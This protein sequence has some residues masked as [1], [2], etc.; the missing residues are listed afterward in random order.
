MLHIGHGTQYKEKATGTENFSPCHL[1]DT[2]LQMSDIVYFETL[3]AED[4]AEDLVDNSTSAESSTDEEDDDRQA[5]KRATPTRH[6]PDTNYHLWTLCNAPIMNLLISGNQPPTLS[7]PPT[8]S[9]LSG[10]N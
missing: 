6:I 10:R 1:S 3:S 4:L 9:H 8:A 7:W 2:S 5:K